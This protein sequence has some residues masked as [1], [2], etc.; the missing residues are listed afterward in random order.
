[1]LN[2]AGVSEKRERDRVRSFL[3]EKESKSEVT[4]CEVEMMLTDIGMLGP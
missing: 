4:E 3:G 2:V 1:M